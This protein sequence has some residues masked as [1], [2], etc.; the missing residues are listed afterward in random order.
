MHIRSLVTNIYIE[1]SIYDSTNRH[2]VIKCGCWIL[3]WSPLFLVEVLALLGKV[4]D[5]MLAVSMEIIFK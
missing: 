2:I 5:G 4:P 3:L 1:E